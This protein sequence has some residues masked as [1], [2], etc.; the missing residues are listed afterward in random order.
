M[1]SGSEPL[2]VHSKQQIRRDLRI[3]H[4]EVPVS[5]SFAA[6][7]IQQRE[8]GGAGEGGSLLDEV[9]DTTGAEADR[10]EFARILVGKS[11]SLVRR[12]LRRVQ[13]TKVIRVSRTALFRSLLSKLSH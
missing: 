13:A 2:N 1:W 7:A 11:P 4:R 3:V 6:A 9:V 12:C 5:S 10:D 8:V